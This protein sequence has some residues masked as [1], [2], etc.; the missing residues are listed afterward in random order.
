MVSEGIYDE[1]GIKRNIIK[2]ENSTSFVVL[3]SGMLY[4]KFGI[5]N[6]VKAIHQL[7]DSDIRLE[8]YGVGDA[9]DDI[10]SVADSDNRIQY[11]G[12]V[13][14]DVVLQKQSEASLLVNPRVPDNNPFTRYSFPSK[15]LEYL[16]SGTPTLLYELEGIPS[17]YYDYCYHLDKQHTDIDSLS[18]EI[19]QIKAMSVAE[20]SLH[21]SP[22]QWVAKYTLLHYK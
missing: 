4:H 10:L 17:E 21:S 5:M 3:Y 13:D 20:K 6:L 9:V 22:T 12:V 8:L 11:K 19:A 7:E 15:T 2:E 1:T 16:A 14:R 18:A